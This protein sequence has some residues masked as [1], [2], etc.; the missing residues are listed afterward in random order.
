M[1]RS[2]S[3]KKATILSTYWISVFSRKSIFFT[4]NKKYT[5]QC[6][7]YIFEDFFFSPIFFPKNKKYNL[8]CRNYIF[9]DFFSPFFFAPPIALDFFINY[10]RQKY[11]IPQRTLDFSRVLFIV[12]TARKIGPK[13]PNYP[14]HPVYICRFTL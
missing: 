8:Q 6:R 12:V 14:V 13:G 4:R 1:S 5:L 11:Q 9:E 7:N 10:F 3:S 2:A